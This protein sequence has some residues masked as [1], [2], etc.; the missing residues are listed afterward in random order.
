MVHLRLERV[1][2]LVDHG[3]FIPSRHLV[4][5]SL[6]GPLPKLRDDRDICSLP[7]CPVGNRTYLPDFF[8]TSHSTVTLFARLRGLS[9]SQ[10]LISV[11]PLQL[12]AYHIA[13]LRGIM[14]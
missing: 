12:L 8:T 14:K 2:T 5:R 11:V 3:P 13:L 9:T 7:G 6:E 10:P 1:N 4:N